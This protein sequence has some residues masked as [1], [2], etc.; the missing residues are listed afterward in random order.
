VLVGGVIVLPLLLVC[1]ALVTFSTLTNRHIAQ[2]LGDSYVESAAAGVQNQIGRYLADAVRVSDQYARMIERGA[3]PTTKLTAWEP[4]MLDDLAT[5]PAIASI[6]FGNANTGEST[7]LLHNKGRLEVGRVTGPGADQAVEYEMHADGSIN[8]KPIRRYLYDVRLR[9]WWDV[10]IKARRPTW[11]PIYFWFGATAL[12]GTASTGHTRLIRDSR[13]NLEGV[14]IVD[15][16]LGDIGGFLRRMSMNNKGYFYIIDD[17]D[18]LVATS[19]GHAIGPDGVRISVEQHDSPP[20]KSVAAAL[21]DWPQVR[22]TRTQRVSFGDVA[23]KMSVVRLSPYDGIDWRLVCVLPESEFLAD[24]NAALQRET[25]FTLM[26]ILGGVLLALM[27]GRQVT[28]PLLKLS[29]HIRRVGRGDFDSRLD[30]DAAREL[31]VLS[32]EINQMAAGLKDHVA[33]K[34]AMEVAREVQQSLL[35]ESSRVFPGLEVAGRSRYCD[36]TGGDYF[37]YLP[38]RRKG[39]EAT[40]ISVGDVMGH[41]IAAALLMTSA[42]AALRVQCV[43]ESHLGRLLTG[44]NDLLAHDAKHGSF[45]TM[46]LAAIDPARGTLHWASAGHDLPIVYHAD[47]DQFA[48]LHGSHIPLGVMEQAAYEEYRYDGLTPGTVILL[49]TD[50]IWETAGRDGEMFG[51]ERVTALLRDCHLRSPRQ[52][53]DELESAL[54]AHRGTGQPS[55]DITFVVVK[56][57]DDDAGRAD[58]SG[59]PLPVA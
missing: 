50:G 42:R 38:L 5:T 20:S 57:R 56:V 51:K 30:L 43:S 21:R 12:D 47:R 7:W 45:M 28:Q 34:Q 36:Q 41:G 49:G 18:L 26:A 22:A 35:P 29:Q 15:V 9:P 40:L 52:I 25:L 17:Q 23:A 13:G 39:G 6:C 44:I 1:T 2:D 53:A 10:A 27:F 3:L 59:G 11:T 4:T 16:T 31:R 33:M 19:H 55:D 58:G 54:G 48:A 24:A 32:D 46:V 37:D 14:L 8:P